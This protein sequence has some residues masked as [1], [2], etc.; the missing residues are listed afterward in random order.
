MQDIKCDSNRVIS[1]IIHL[2]GSKQM[3]VIQ[4]YAPTSEY[5]DEVVEQIYDKINMDIEESKAEYTIVMGDF[6]AKIGE[7]Q[8]GEESIKNQ[9]DFILSSQHGIIEDCSV[10]TNVDIGSDHI[11]W[12]E[13]WFE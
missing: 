1:L 12:S 3:C 11:R 2:T 4:V 5:A 9:I 8:P 6:N 10:I 13:Q 7:C